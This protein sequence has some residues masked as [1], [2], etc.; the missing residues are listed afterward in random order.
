MDSTTNSLTNEEFVIIE[1]HDENN[2]DQGEQSGSI[3]ININ[4]TSI[5]F[6]DGNSFGHLF[7]HLSLSNETTSNTALV[8][9]PLTDGNIQANT[10]MASLVN[11]LEDSIIVNANSASANS[12]LINAADVESIETNL[13]T[14]I[15]LAKLLNNGIQ[16]KNLKI[17][18]LEQQQ[19]IQQSNFLKA[20]TDHNEEVFK[21]GEELKDTREALEKANEDSK[22][23]GSELQENKSI[24]DKLHTQIH[25]Q[26][27]KI[28]ALEQQQAIQQ[29]NFLK[30]KAD[31]DEEVFKLGEK[32]KHTLEALEKANEDSKMIGSELQEN[33]SIMDKLHT[34]IHAQTLKIADLE[35][36]QG[37]QQSNFLKYKA[38]HDEEVFK[39]G[40]ELKDTLEALE[41]ANEDSKKIGSELQENKCIMDK[42][43]TQIHAQ[44]LKIA[45][46]EHQQ[47]IQQSNFLKSKG[48][49]DEESSA[50]RANLIKLENV[51]NELEL[52]LKETITEKDLALKNLRDQ[53]AHSQNV[54]AQLQQTAEKKNN[55]V[56]NELENLREE[57]AGLKNKLKEEID[58]HL[59]E[60]DLRKMAEASLQKAVEARF[61][62]ARQLAEKTEYSLRLTEE[63]AKLRKDLED[64]NEALE[65]A[66]DPSKMEH[67]NRALKKVFELGEELKDTLEALEKANEDSKKIGSELQEN[68]SIVDKLHTQIHAQNLKIADLEQQQGIQ[69]SNF[70]KSKAD[71]DEESSAARANLIKLENVKNELELKLKKTITEKDLALKKAKADN[72]EESYAA[73]V[74]FDELENVNN[75]LELKLKETIT[76]K[77]SALKNLRVQLAH[78]QNVAIQLKQAGEKKRQ[79]NERLTNKLDETL[80]EKLVNTDLAEITATEL[81]KDQQDNK[82]LFADLEQL[83]RGL[84]DNL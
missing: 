7:G 39:L 70:L 71:H 47:A 8:E 59:E 73:Q 72:D 16:E 77:D 51:K 12:S 64:A 79:E 83:C 14:A 82:Q 22:K 1:T 21:L 75:K 6:N 50:A 40:E 38:D 81:Q 19:A 74:Q 33:K 56:L 3:Q 78:S 32:L 26:N 53:L 63:N 69:Q 5:S 76:E 57:N 60:I 15:R 24:V 2:E 23:I 48:D 61:E 9:T 36:Q 31:H 37:I 49:H 43:H 62:E 52:K 55:D 28:A 65:K 10:P 46:L 17:A 68:K 44:T 42:L 41:K 66:K 4:P 84:V 25:A 35:H 13:R 80:A 67:L 27:L 29:S 34:E 54:A 18:E 58:R 30:S 45:D 11:V 20:K